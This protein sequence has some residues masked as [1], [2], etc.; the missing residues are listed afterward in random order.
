MK[1]FALATTL[2]VIGGGVAFA[3]NDKVGDI[4]IA[5]PWAP[6]M[7]GSQLT[8]SA[9][10]MS[11]TDH[12]TAPDELISASSPVAQKVQ[13]HVFDVENGVYGMRRVDA[14]AVAPGAAATVLRPGGAHVMLEGLKQPLQAGDTFP[15]S[16]TFKHAG[17]IQVKVQVESPQTAMANVSR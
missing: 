3:Q 9:A 15:L 17:E 1:T 5:R 10:Y 13:L 2:L 8:N 11:L 7:S 16:L 12:G 6:A 14:I 4:E